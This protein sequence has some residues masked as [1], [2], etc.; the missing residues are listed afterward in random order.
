MKSYGSVCDYIFKNSGIPNTFEQKE[1]IVNGLLDGY[2]YQVSLVVSTLDGRT[3]SNS[4]TIVPAP[5]GA[6]EVS[7]ESSLVKIN[8]NS[9]L[10]LAGTISAYNSQYA[11][12]NFDEPSIDL[13]EIAL[14][15]TYKELSLIHI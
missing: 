11:T 3:S 4:T 15:P 7:T 2:I 12:W 14:T 5:P 10:V 1:I 8:Y 6:P 9:R 13:N